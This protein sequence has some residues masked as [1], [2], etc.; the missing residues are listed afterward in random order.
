[1]NG[2]SIAAFA[3][4]KY[5]NLLKDAKVSFGNHPE[6]VAWKCHDAKQHN[7]RHLAFNNKNIREL[8]Y[9]HATAQAL[10]QFKLTCTLFRDASKVVYKA[11][12]KPVNYQ[13]FESFETYRETSPEDIR[14]TDLL[15]VNDKYA[16][17]NFYPQDKSESN[18]AKGIWIWNR[19]TNKCE[20]RW[21]E[22]NCSYTRTPEGYVVMS[23]EHAGPPW[24]RERSISF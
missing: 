21:P 24:P 23:H 12:A 3:H 9:S 16:I 1:M 13:K 20:H 15:V 11:P 18:K 8:I 4:K 17:S 19:K 5:E 6:L 10:S 7:Q 22:Q 14:T 2:T